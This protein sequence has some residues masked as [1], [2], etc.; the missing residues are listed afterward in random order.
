MIDAR[1]PLDP[2]GTRLLVE[3]IVQQAMIDFHS[4]H[5]Y[6]TERR[7]LERFFRSSYFESLTGLNGRSILKKLTKLQGGAGK[8]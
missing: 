6:S 2:D 3:A 4:S 1:K 5:P 7:E 8:R